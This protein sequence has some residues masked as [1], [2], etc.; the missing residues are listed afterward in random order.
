M[1]ES[2]QHL[3]D[4]QRYI[5]HVLREVVRVLDELNIPY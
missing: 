1:A 5:L 3:N 2:Q 4:T